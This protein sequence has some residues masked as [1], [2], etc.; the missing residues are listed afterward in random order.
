MPTMPQMAVSRDHTLLVANT[1]SGAT[2]A[3]DARLL[4]DSPAAARHF[5]QQ[6]LDILV[7]GRPLGVNVMPLCERDGGLAIVASLLRDAATEAGADP[8]RI[9]L[10]IGPGGP[11]LREAWRARARHLG[12]GP[13]FIATGQATDWQALWDLRNE[14]HLRVAAATEVTS[15]CRLLACEPATV[16][17]PGLQVQAPVASAWVGRRIWLPDFIAADGHVDEAGLLRAAERAVDSGDEAFADARWPTSRMRHDAWLNRRLAVELDGIGGLVAALGLD[18]ADFSTLLVL[19]RLVAKLRAALVR[20]SRRLADALG[21]AP[22]L[23][24]AARIPPMADERLRE[25]WLRRWQ[26]AVVSSAQR[27]RNL[28]VIS[29][30]SLFPEGEAAPCR[31]ANLVPLL[32]YADACAVPEPPDISAWTRAEFVNFY[33]QV[34]AVLQQRSAQRQIAESA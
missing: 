27:H 22:V 7:T 33:R 1:Q 34:G 31:Y 11:A 23:E 21:P 15:A 14:P 16:V 5:V 12:P 6:S 25:S 26:Q 18:P 20:R 29:P 2:L 10:T 8:A 17:V 24:Q 3:A 28:V 32:R 4:A 19:S 13:L 30:W 9:G